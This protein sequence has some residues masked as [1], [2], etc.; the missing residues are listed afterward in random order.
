D[1]FYT[2]GDSSGDSSG[3]KVASALCATAEGPTDEEKDSGEMKF[4]NLKS[5]HDVQ[6]MVK[7]QK[8]LHKPKKESSLV[9]LWKSMFSEVTGGKYCENL[10]AKQ[11]GQLREFGKKCP[12]NKADLIL[13]NVMENW[14]DFAKDVETNQG[15]KK[16]PN[17]PQIGFL[18]QYVQNAVSV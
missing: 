4:D 14:H 1:F 16:T 3:D 7:A 10:T 2:T 12:P 18:L 5:V 11:I 8:L 9:I 17:E 6:G 15:L 13:A